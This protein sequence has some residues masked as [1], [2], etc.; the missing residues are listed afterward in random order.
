MKKQTAKKILSLTMVAIGIV[1]IVFAV[2]CLKAEKEYGYSHYWAY[3]ETVQEEVYNG[4]A[5][6]GM[7]NAMAQAANNINDLNNNAWSIYYELQEI[8]FTIYTCTGYI[9]LVS[10]ILLLLF[11]IMKTLFAFL[12]ENKTLPNEHI[13]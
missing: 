4:D 5:Y 6:T 7:Q 10:G 2:L 3:G 1:A 11:G 9:L 8:R 12:K 13:S